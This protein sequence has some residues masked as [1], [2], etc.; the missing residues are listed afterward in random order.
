M[1]HNRFCINPHLLFYDDE[2]GPSSEGVLSICEPRGIWARDLKTVR[3]DD[4]YRADRSPIV[5]LWIMRFLTAWFVA[6]GMSASAGDMANLSFEHAMIREA[7][8][9]GGNTAGYVQ[10][11]N[12]GTLA[13]RLIAAHIDVAGM[14]EIHEMAMNDGVMQMRPLEDGIEIAP[15]E[16]VALAPGGLHLMVMKTNQSLAEGDVVPVVLTFENAGD[17]HVEFIVAPLGAILKTR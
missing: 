15:G 14:T 11:L 7:P 9:Q 8:V 2:Y 6:I 10:I 12:E 5:R 3:R 13:D 4:M 17:V 1:G 16:T